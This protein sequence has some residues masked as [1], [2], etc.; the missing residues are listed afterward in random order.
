MIYKEASK[1]KLRIQTTKGHLNVEQLWGLSLAELD[2]LAVSLEEAYKNSKSK[3]FLDKKSEKDKIVKLRFDIVLD[4][5]NTK[6]EEKEAAK[7]EAEDKEHNQKILSIIKEKQD[8]DLK[9]KSI[10][11]LEKM[12]KENSK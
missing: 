10:K 5:L 4:V 1:L 2:A 6:V 9:G 8:E 7:K 12:L 3:S 11:E